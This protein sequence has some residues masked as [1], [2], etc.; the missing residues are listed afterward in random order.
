MRAKPMRRRGERPGHSATT[1]HFQAA[2]PF[3]GMGALGAPGVYVGTDAFGGAWAF[4]PWEL[5]VRKA[6][7]SPNMIVMGD[8]AHLKSTLIKTFLYRSYVFGRQ[9]WILDV[10]GEFGPFARA[11]GY[12]TI[13]LEPGG[14]LRLNA[15][16]RR[17]G[18]E[19]QLALLRTVTMAALRRDLQPEEDAALRV[20][21]DQVNEEAGVFEPT[22]PMVVDVLLHPREAMVSGVSAVGVAE[23][24][25]AARDCALALQRLCEGDLRGMFDGPT[26]EGIDLDAGVVV[27]DLSAMRDS[28]ALGVLMTCA[29]AWQQAI[30]RERKEISDRTGEPMRKTF[31][32]FEEVWRVAANVAVGEWLQSNFKLCRAFGIANILSLHKLTDF[33][34]AGSDGSRAARIAEALVDDAGCVVIFRQP[35]DQ[36]K[37][38]HEVLGCSDTEAQ[39]STTLDI[40][41]AI[42]KIG[43]RSMLVRLRMSRQ[44]HSIT[45]TDEQMGVHGAARMP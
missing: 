11:L 41:E 38:L 22:L 32:V 40:G 39:L 15:I 7:R 17:G 28:E 5:Y 14:E 43:R 23:F 10:K 19:G 9:F 20:A 27:L 6:I 4:D 33:G 30:F 37:V 34:T 16:E 2:Y 42:W 29:G 26:S 45:F 25:A 3:L 8:I 12:P 13:R 35:P 1:A 36:R 21:L 24:A 18:R 31:C 44:E